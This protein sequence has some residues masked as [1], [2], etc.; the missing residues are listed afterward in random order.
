MAA[1]NQKEKEILGEPIEPFGRNNRGK[2]IEKDMMEGEGHNEEFL[3]LIHDGIENKRPENDYVELSSEEVEII[4]TSGRLQEKSFLWVLDEV[5]IK[6]LRE[7]TPNVLRT[8]N[9]IICHTNITVK[10]LI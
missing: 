1:L 10:K 8:H 2:T 9:K 7:T 3:D 5:S 4:K 6:I